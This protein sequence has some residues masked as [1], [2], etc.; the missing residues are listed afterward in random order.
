MT[1]TMMLIAALAALAACARK[2]DAP[3]DPAALIAGDASSAWIEMMGIWA[4]PGGCG[5]ATIE[6]RIEAEAFH[7]YEAHC[8]VGRLE[9]LQNGVR[10]IAHC[11]IE[12]DD[13]GVEDAFKFVRREDATLTIINEA[14]GAE[15]TGLAPCGEDMIP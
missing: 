10:A 6:W 1:R 15:T 9:L 4:P 14:N 5:D 12:G 3:A 7:Q 13:D 11:S 8:A 2:E